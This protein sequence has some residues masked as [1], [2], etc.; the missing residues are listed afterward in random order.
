MIKRAL[1]ILFI[2]LTNALL[3]ILGLYIYYSFTDS[4]T[5]RTTNSDIV[6]M[7]LFP[8]LIIVFI[9]Y[10]MVTTNQTMRKFCVGIFSISYSILIFLIFFLN[11]TLATEG[12]YKTYKLND[13]IWMDDR[14]S[15]SIDF[16]D[17]HSPTKVTQDKCFKVDSV[18]L[19]VDKGLFGMKVFTN[20]VLLKE[21]SNCGTYRPANRRDSLNINLNA[22]HFYATK[23]C[24]SLAINEYTKAIEA[25]SLDAESFYHRGEM[26]LVKNDYKKALAD[27]YAAAYIHYA[28][29]DSAE[30][31]NLT[32]IKLNSYVTNFI[33]NIESKKA[34]EIITFMD[35][36][37]LVDDFD[38]Y[39]KR[40]KF[41]KDKL[42]LH[43]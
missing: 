42:G 14:C 25:D 27:F 9:F 36:T 34:D 40:I 11:K 24:F 39:Q 16:T 26:F 41:C 13:A 2:V 10:L 7:S 35:N 15:L 28:H 20:N 29:L 32:T 33:D 31:H 21:S 22:G 38:S 23:R 37:A 17:W 30:L 1:T 43:E 4:I 6:E 8:V 5:R 18:Q 12:E 3:L 19:R